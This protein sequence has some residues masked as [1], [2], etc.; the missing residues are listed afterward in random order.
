MPASTPGGC[1]GGSGTTARH[2]PRNSCGR[3]GPRA[4]DSPGSLASQYG[5]PLGYTIT[6]GARVPDAPAHATA[7]ALSANH[8]AARSLVLG[9][10]LRSA[11]NA[12]LDRGLA[13]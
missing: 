13:S 6:R 7:T 5:S 11:V 3:T 8:A 9:V 10:V 1:H 4:H 12:A 2:T